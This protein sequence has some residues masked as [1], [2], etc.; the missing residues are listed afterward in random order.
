MEWKT[1]RGGVREEV[2]DE[3]VLAVVASERA[4]G[5]VLR[6]VHRVQVVRARGA[7]PREGAGGGGGRGDTA[8]PGPVGAILAV[9]DEDVFGG[10]GIENDLAGARRGEARGMKQV[11]EGKQG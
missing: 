3:K 8:Q 4:S 9:E 1:I 7:L 10:G 5:H 6:H 2:E 11:V